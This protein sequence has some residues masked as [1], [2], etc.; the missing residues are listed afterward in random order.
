MMPPPNLHRTLDDENP[1][2]E[3]LQILGRQ[4]RERGESY[5]I[6]AGYESELR[7][8]PHDKTLQLAFLRA[9]PLDRDNPN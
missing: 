8:R 1:D 4:L 2:D 3:A 5:L 6:A 7:K 9:V